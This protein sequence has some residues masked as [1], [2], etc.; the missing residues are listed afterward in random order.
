[1]AYAALFLVA[2]LPIALLL[3]ILWASGKAVELIASRL[4]KH[5]ADNARISAHA[6]RSTYILVLAFIAYQIY[7][8]VYPTDDFFLQ[9]Y[10]EVTLRPAPHTAKVIAK[11]ASYPDFHGDYCSYSRIYLG[12]ESFEKLLRELEG[13]PRI[14][15]GNG[16]G[17]SEEIKVQSRVKKLSVKQSFIRPVENEADHHLSITFLEDGI[18]V[19]VNI[20]VT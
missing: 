1:V 4:L 15:A 14:Q 17:S 12:A 13:D 7:F 8:A 5:R 10:Q 16:I 6:R 20:C 9:E 2:L 11:S 18:H 19:E 3:F